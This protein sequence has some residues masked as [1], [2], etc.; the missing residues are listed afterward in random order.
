VVVEG[1]L[2]LDRDTD[3]Y[4]S[5]IADG[6]NNMLSKINSNIE[7]NVVAMEQVLHEASSKSIPNYSSKLRQ[8]PTGKSIWNRG[9][10]EAARNARKSHLIW[11]EGGTSQDRKDPLKMQKITAKRLLRKAQRQAYASS[12]NSW[13]RKIM[14]ELGIDL[15][16]ASCITCFIAT[17]LSSM[18]LLILLSML[19]TPSAIVNL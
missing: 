3:I 11:K 18:L 7:D 9:I 1:T 8:K 19:F 13:A 14:D 5:T 4:R 12:R 15:E 6:V 16:E 2:F 17:T 10:A